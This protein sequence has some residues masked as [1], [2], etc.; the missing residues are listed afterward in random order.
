MWEHWWSTQMA[1]G[2]HEFKWNPSPWRHVFPSHVQLLGWE[3]A[4][5]R[6]RGFAR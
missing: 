4:K 5:S 2:G 6:W 3:L 1:L